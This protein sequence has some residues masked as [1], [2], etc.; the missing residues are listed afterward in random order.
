MRAPFARAWLAGIVLL[1]AS[2]AC[3]PTELVDASGREIYVELCARCHGVQLEGGVAPA[4]EITPETTDEYLATVIRDGV[5][6]M[7][8]FGPTLSDEQIDRVVDHLRT[9]SRE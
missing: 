3:A 2:T 6:V 7:A 9:A 4:I 8:G 5:G 1:V